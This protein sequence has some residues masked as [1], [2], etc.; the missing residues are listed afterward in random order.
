MY[1][2]VPAFLICADMGK[3]LGQSEGIVWYYDLLAHLPEEV[4]S[5]TIFPLQA[6]DTNLVR[7]NPGPLDAP[8]CVPHQ[9]YGDPTIDVSARPRVVLL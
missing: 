4:E 8:V 5:G 9:S 2:H 1:I 7:Q 6:M 3:G